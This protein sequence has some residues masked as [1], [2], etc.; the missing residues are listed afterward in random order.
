[1]FNLYS[2]CSYKLYTYNTTGFRI[3]ILQQN[4]ILHCAIDRWIDRF[5]RVQRSI[6]RVRRKARWVDASC[7]RSTL[8]RGAYDCPLM[9]MKLLMMGGREMFGNFSNMR[10]MRCAKKK[11]LKTWIFC[12]KNVY[13]WDQ[14]N[15]WT[16]MISWVQIND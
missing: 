16:H 8:I 15:K 14:R 12:R 11:K 1:M 13:A 2:K 5:F 9:R 7:V 3:K 10:S 6:A 4:L